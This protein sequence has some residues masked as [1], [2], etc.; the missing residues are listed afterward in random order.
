MP[1][2]CAMQTFGV[3][4]AGPLPGLTKLGLCDNW[5]GSRGACALAEAQLPALAHLD[6]AR[7]RV[8]D[9]GALALA[10]PTNLPALRVI[11]VWDNLISHQGATALEGRPGLR[12][13]IG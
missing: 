5:I 9:E 11:N 13:A 4:S 10:H 3:S 7:N 8:G 6:L 12:V 1:L 2:G